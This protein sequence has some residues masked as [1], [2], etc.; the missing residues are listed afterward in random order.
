M[1]CPV[2]CP[3]CGSTNVL[4]APDEAPLS[5]RQW[6]KCWVCG[7][8]WDQAGVITKVDDEVEQDDESA[9]SLPPKRK[10]TVDELMSIVNT[11]VKDA[12]ARRG[13]PTKG[14]DMGVKTDADGDRC[15]GRQ[16]R[17]QCK[18]SKEPGSNYCQAHSGQ[19]AAHEPAAKRQ[20]KSSRSRAK[21]APA[22]PTPA[23]T[24]GSWKNDVLERL[25]EQRTLVASQLASIDQAIV[26]ITE[27]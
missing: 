12:R 1:N 24:D 20:P 19:A 10:R 17:G 13:E 4:A 22:V 18:K 5:A 3:K 23:C 15:E 6:M 16:G 26:T 21:V 25:N 7:K 14:D 27:I 2:N 8:R 11:V 9:E